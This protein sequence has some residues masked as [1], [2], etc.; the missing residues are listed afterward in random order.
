METKSLPAMLYVYV[1]AGVYITTY[2]ISYYIQIIFEL[3]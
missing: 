3:P 2:T 1:N